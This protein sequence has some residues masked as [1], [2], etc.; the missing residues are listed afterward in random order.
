V[1]RPGGLLRFGVFEL[2]L[3]A[4]ELRRRG[5]FVPLP[6]QPFAVLA[7]LAARPGEVVTRDELRHVLWADGVHVDHERGLNYC[8]NRV[9]HALGDSAASPRFVE[10]VP[11]LGYR[12][13]ATVEVV[14]A[15]APLEPATPAQSPSHDETG[16]RGP[17]LVLAA[18]LV[19]AL[20]TA[21]LPRRS[22]AGEPGLPSP[23]PLAQAAFQ[24][25]RLL[26]D[27]G[28][29]GWRRSVSCFAEA[30]R[31][32]GGFALARYGLAD[33]YLRLGEHGVLAADLAFP[34][35]RAAATQAL[36]IEDRAEPLVILAALKLNYEWDWAGAEQ[37]YLHALALDPDLTG[38][39]LG[40]ARFLSAAGRHREALRTI[41]EAEARRPGCVEIVRDAGFTHYRAH[42]LA[43]AARRFRGWAEL[44]PGSRDPH[45]WLALLHH[46]DGRLSDA[47][48][49]A[50]LVLVMAGASAES[51]G[52]FD[53]LPPEL[54]MERYLRGCLGFLQGLSS[55]QWVT[56]DDF[57]RI[58]AHLGERKS[59]LDDLE[60]AAD[61]RSPRLLPFLADPA[62]DALRSDPRFRALLRRV[63]VPDE[64]GDPGP[65]FSVAALVP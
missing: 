39:R 4:R 53:S 35:S 14:P 12:F 60:R 1:T 57:A 23:D 51:L 44:E 65:A 48:R 17:L 22:R 28:P 54:A 9:R 26:L 24:K 13:L 2:D 20:Q 52:R 37:A 30:A 32:D 62:F 58:R 42:E 49:E 36:E 11:R 16:S 3:E 5:A 50:R 55:S 43:E 8:V 59:A 45:H 27:E 10:T 64:P 63:G 21:G 46:L 56:A 19:L 18:A 41:H 61:E 38:A 7:C 15:S 40:Y 47:K 34:A 33:A 29:T 31:R 25:G 6:P